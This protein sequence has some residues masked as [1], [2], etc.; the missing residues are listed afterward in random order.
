MTTE[1][2]CTTI[3]KQSFE[4]SNVTE[5]ELAHKIG[6]SRRTIANWKDGYSFPTMP[7]MIKWFSALKTRMIPWLLKTQYIDEHQESKKPEKEIEQDLTDF[8]KGL[9]PAQKERLHFIFC[10]EH[11]SAPDGVLEMVCSHLHTPLRDRFRVA[12]LIMLNYEMAR[13]NHSLVLPD[14]AEPNIVILE[15]SI[16]KGREAILQG[17]QAYIRKDN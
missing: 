13:A 15:E 9:T 11:G 17:F 8:L 16:E 6:V 3:L 12:S 7:Q 14:T 1:E 2:K 5:E 4:V 10:G